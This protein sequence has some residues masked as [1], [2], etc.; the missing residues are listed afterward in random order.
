MS[1]FAS[2]PGW[3][4]KLRKPAPAIST[5]SQRSD[6]EL[7]LHLLGELAGIHLARLGDGHESVGLVIAKLRIGTRA[8]E[9]RGGV[10]VG[11]DG[12]HRGLETL[13]EQ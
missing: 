4:R 9:Q 10:R 12:G 11:Q 6:V 2:A 8:D 3:S 7:R 5:V 1:V 13:F